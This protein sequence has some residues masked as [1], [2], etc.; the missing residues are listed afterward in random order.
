MLAR[1]HAVLDRLLS[2][3]TIDLL[4]PT[5]RELLAREWNASERPVS[6]DTIA[7]LLVAQAERT[8]DA[9]ALVFGDERVSC[10]ELV[11][12]IKRTADCLIAGGAGP[13]QVVAV[14]LPGPTDMVV[15]LFAVLRTGAAYLPLDLDHPPDRLSW[16]LD[17]TQPLCVLN[18]LPDLG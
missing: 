14:A 15:A 2:N 7:D 6:E 9:I 5:E 11:D 18:V 10:R 4:L 3:S 13:E 17:D 12:R 8:P 16:M 1:Y